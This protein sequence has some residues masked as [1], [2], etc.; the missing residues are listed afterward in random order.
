MLNGPILRRD[1][2]E[3][4]WR[5]ISSRTEDIARS[6]GTGQATR[7]TWARGSRTRRIAE[8]ARLIVSLG[9]SPGS[10]PGLIV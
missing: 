8:S 2:E 9:L 1:P 10:G 6:A 7:V 3:S 4:S 5:A